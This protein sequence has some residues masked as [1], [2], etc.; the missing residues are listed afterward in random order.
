[1]MRGD[2]YIEVDAYPGGISV[3]AYDGSNREGIALQLETDSGWE[4]IV[5]CVLRQADNVAQILGT[6]VSYNQVWCEHRARRIGAWH[7]MPERITGR[8][9][10]DAERARV[11]AVHGPMGTGRECALTGCS[12][13]YHATYQEGDSEPLDLCVDHYDQVAR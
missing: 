11:L 8:A 2:G 1:M 7:P 10:E 4:G 12:E 3:Y 9:A 6:Y 13:P 5:D